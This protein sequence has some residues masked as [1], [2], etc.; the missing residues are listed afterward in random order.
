MERKLVQVEFGILLFSI[1]LWAVFYKTYAPFVMLAAII[2]HEAGHLLA[3]AISKNRFKRISLQA[4][5][6]VLGGN[7]NFASYKSE[8]FIALCGPLLNILS[9]LLTAKSELPLISLFADHSF[10]LA[11]I[12]LLP[13]DG[14]DGGRLASCLLSCFLPPKACSILCDVLSFLALFFLWSI[15]VYLMLKTDRNISPFV[16]SASVFLKI[17]QKSP[18]KRICEIIRE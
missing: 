6:L 4:G 12:N 10:A 2:I 13:I 18:K 7:R 1:M 14:F 8:A 9:R 11:L 5:G 16:F 15:S 3:S 17:I